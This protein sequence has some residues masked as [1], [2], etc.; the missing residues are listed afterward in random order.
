M[1]YAIIHAD[2]RFIV[3]ILDFQYTTANPYNHERL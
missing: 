1:L 2:P 3:I